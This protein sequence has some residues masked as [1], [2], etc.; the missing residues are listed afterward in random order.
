MTDD[1]LMQRLQDG[2]P[3]VLL[4]LKKSH[5]DRYSFLRGRLPVSDVT[6]DRDFQRTFNGLYRVRQRS[7]EWKLA[8]YGLM[9]RS[10]LKPGPDFA[11]TLNA[12]Y[13]TTQRVEASFASKLV[14]IINP[15]LAVYD[16]V[17][18][19]NLCFTPPRQ[20]RPTEE[21]LRDFVL[22]Y[23]GLNERMNRLIR[24]QSFPAM[25]NAL[26]QAFPD[27]GIT[28]IRRMDLLLW[29]LRQRQHPL[30][31]TRRCSERPSVV[32]ELIR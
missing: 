5:F 8:Y 25:S 1:E 30:R 26:E 15:D 6:N 21:R 24:H 12:L 16:S 9:E 19:Q 4:A 7:A 17:V 11:A 2:L 22:L 13:T 14:A 29:Q 27:Y 20:Y 32:A 10:K 23:K 18:A 3:K 28:P 31:L